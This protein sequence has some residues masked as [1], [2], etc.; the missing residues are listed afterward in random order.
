MASSAPSPLTLNDNDKAQIIRSVLY[1]ELTKLKRLSVPKVLL[2]DNKHIRPDWL[3]TILNIEVGLLDQAEIKSSLAAD[4]V[5]SYFFIGEF[6]IKD[7]R[8]RISFG[9][10]EESKRSSSGS[11][12]IYEY[13][14]VSGKWRGRIVEGFGYCAAPGA[15]NK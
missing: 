15:E 2:L 11:G 14:R 4:K 9:K 12:S 7:Q 6:E 3:P 10:H 1:R 8:V 13:R 5:I